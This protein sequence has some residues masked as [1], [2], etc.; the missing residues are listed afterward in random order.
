M[1][2]K[3]IL[4]INILSIICLSQCVS[5]KC[6]SHNRCN[7]INQ[8][9]YFKKIKLEPG[10][11]EI[12]YE[13]SWRIY[14]DIRINVNI[15]EP[16]RD[17]KLSAYIMT[18]NDFNSYTAANNSIHDIYGYEGIIIFENIT[19]NIE[20]YYDSGPE[21]SSKYIIF[22]NNGDKKIKFT[23][24]IYF[25]HILPLCIKIILGIFAGIFTTLITGIVMSHCS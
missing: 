12:I 9:L 4:M 14:N 25:E 1:I 8:M 15:I 2:L 21:F 23:Y 19:R 5:V 16:T 18:D 11:M 17:Q 3:L 10:E 24:K 6:D 22:K 13:D 7:I 20:R